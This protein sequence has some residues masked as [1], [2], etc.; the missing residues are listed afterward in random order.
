MELGKSGVK[1]GKHHRIASS[2]KIGMVLCKTV[3]VTAACI[4]FQ[5]NDRGEIYGLPKSTIV[6]PV[7]N[8]NETL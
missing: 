7:G 4:H 3:M 1:D 2:S 8:C 6:K 5:L